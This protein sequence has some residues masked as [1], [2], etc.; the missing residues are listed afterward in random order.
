MVDGQAVDWNDNKWILLYKTA[1]KSLIDNVQWATTRSERK[2]Y[3][4]L[5]LV[6]ALRAEVACIYNSSERTIIEVFV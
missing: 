3:H 1:Y 2:Q 4:L 5:A 6:A